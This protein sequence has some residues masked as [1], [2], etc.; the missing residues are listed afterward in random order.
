MPADKPAELSRIKLKKMNSTAR[1]YDQRVFNPLDP[2][3]SWL[4][5]L[6]LAIYMFMVLISILWHRQAIFESKGD[7]LFSSDECRIRTQ[8]R[9][10]QK[11]TYIHTYMFVVDFYAL[12]QASDFQIERRHVVFLC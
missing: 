9:R 8:G 3:A 1:P 7:K 12:A 4:L 5:H 2:I 6:A 11:H 10:H